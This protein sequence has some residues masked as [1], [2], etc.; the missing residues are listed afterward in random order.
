MY[1]IVNILAISLI[2][3]QFITGTLAEGEENFSFNRDIK[4]PDIDKDSVSS[5]YIQ[6]DIPYTFK[7][8]EDDKNFEAEPLHIENAKAK[9]EIVLI[10]MHQNN[11]PLNT[12]PTF[13][14]D[15]RTLSWGTPYE[16]AVQQAMSDLHHAHDQSALLQSWTAGE[17]RDSI[18][19]VIIPKGAT[20][21]FTIG[22]ASA[23]QGKSEYRAGGG[24]QMRLANLPKGTIVLTTQLNH[25]SEKT[26]Y[27]L[28][29]L[30]EKVLEQYNKQ[31][32]KQK[33]SSVLGDVDIGITNPK[34]Y[35]ED[36]FE[37]YAIK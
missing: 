18:S 23:Q 1:K 5:N 17:I 2:S 29:C 10:N 9:R 32:P 30:F 8:Q 33:L 19:F 20:M 31:E 35:V 11:M 37:K 12:G 7:F 13:K 16:A 27:P 26:T 25:H 3:S 6:Q 34:Q 21:T 28:T 36:V 24:M 4:C 14:K 22:Y 15:H